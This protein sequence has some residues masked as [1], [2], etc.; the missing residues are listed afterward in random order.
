[1]GQIYETSVFMTLD[2]SQQK[3]VIHGTWETIEENSVIDSF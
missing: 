3:T 2:I 1:M